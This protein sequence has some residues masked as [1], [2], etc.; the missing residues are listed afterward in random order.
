MVMVHGAVHRCKCALV[1]MHTQT[2]TPHFAHHGAYLRCKCARVRTHTQTHMPHIADHEHTRFHQDTC[3]MH[4]RDTSALSTSHAAGSKPTARSPCV[5]VHAGVVSAVVVGRLA[6]E[7]CVR[8]AL[9]LNV[10]L[11]GGHPNVPSI[12]FPHPSCSHGA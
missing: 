3:R 11:V 12:H 1:R 4:T 5:V 9:I 10:Q 2:N 7:G 8:G 6:D